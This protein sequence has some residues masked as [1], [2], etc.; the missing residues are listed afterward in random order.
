MRLMQV[1]ETG[2]PE[3]NWA[4]QTHEKERTVKKMMIFGLVMAMALT[5]GMTEIFAQQQSTGQNTATGTWTCPRMAGGQQGNQGR[6]G[7]GRM[8][9]QGRR[10]AADPN[11]PWLT[12]QA[13]PQTA[14]NPPVAQ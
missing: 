6:M 8:R 4:G 12:G 9:G 2:L 13:N 10:M 3:D 11:C 1:K 7:K 14:V 5:F